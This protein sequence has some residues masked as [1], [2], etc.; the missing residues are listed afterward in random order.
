MPRFDLYA[1]PAHQAPKQRGLAL[2]RAFALALLVFGLAFCA[3]LLLDPLQTVSVDREP[4]ARP[5]RP[6]EAVGPCPPAELA[7]VPG[8]GLTQDLERPPPRTR[9]PRER[10]RA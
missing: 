3:T 1:P 10:P 6:V 4:A 5:A 2:V 8:R 7:S 9:Q